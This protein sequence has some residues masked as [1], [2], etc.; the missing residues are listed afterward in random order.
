MVQAH[1]IEQVTLSFAKKI[2]QLKGEVKSLEVVIDEGKEKSKTGKKVELMLLS[3][4][5]LQGQNQFE[6]IQKKAKDQD[7]KEYNYLVDPPTYLNLRYMVAP[8]FASRL[9]NFKVLGM[10]TR[11]LKD[12]NKID[13]GKY[14]WAGNKGNPII[15][16]SEN[17]MDLNKQMQI[18]NMLK[19]DFRPALFFHTSVG[20]ESDKKE[21]FTRVEE[22]I[23]DL[24]K[25]KENE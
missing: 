19:I 1:I 14:D 13:V 22:R 3:V 5:N 25:K 18:F 11:L 12:D 2:E 21:V 20:I 8:S 10:I 9:E 17:D 16:E 7:G 6:K 23:F 24:K 4:E 15:I